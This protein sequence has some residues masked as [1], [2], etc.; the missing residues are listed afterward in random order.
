M[1][2]ACTHAGAHTNTQEYYAATKKD[3][4]LPF[5]TAQMDLEDMTLSEASHTEKDKYRDFIHTWILK[6]KQVSKKAEGD[7]KTIEKKK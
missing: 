7:L 5:V 6:A 3:E 2:H 1:V 4:I